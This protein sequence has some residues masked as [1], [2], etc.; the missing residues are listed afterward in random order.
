MHLVQTKNAIYSN[1]DKI[2]IIQNIT[3]TK[4]KEKWNNWNN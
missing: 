4:Q 3:T 2:I 1:E